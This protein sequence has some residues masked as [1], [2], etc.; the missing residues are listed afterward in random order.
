MALNATSRPTL[1]Q[2]QVLELAR[3]L[4]VSKEVRSGINHSTPPWYAANNGLKSGCAQVTV[5]DKANRHYRLFPRNLLVK[6]VAILLKIKPDLKLPQLIFERSQ[7]F[8]AFDT[9]A[10][11]GPRPP[12]RML[13]ITQLALFAHRLKW[14]FARSTDEED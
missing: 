7:V 13:D 3:N 10:V 6:T 4:S 12:T 11:F 1:K 5:L 14:L 9:I 2:V 8:S